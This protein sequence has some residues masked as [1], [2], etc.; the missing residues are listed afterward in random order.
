[1]KEYKLKSY[2]VKKDIDYKINYDGELNAA[3]LEAVKTKEGPV[4]VIAGAGTGRT[5]TLVYRAARLVEE[6]AN[7]ENILLLTFTRKAALNMLKRASMSLD[8]RC[9]KISGGTFHSFAN[10][11]LRKYAK[12]VG[13]NE[14]FT[15]LD[16]SDAE[17]VIGIIRAKLGYNKTEKRFPLKHTIGEV[18]SKSINKNT[19]VEFVLNSEYPHFIDS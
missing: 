17:S 18:I 7:P 2:N 16:K 1:M 14:N 11:M 10:I 19:L 15:I 8:E 4:L 5:K 9:G 12:L 6:G 13:F 3:Q